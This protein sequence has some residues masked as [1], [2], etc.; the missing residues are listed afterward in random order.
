MP[1]VAGDIKIRLSGGSGNTDPNASLGG[2][3]SSTEVT[4][5]SLHN[6]FDVVSSGESSSGDTEYRCIYVHNGHATLTLQSAKV[7][8]QS[9]TSSGDTS[10]EIALAGEGLNATAETIANE[11]TAPAGET[12]SAP[13]TEGAGLTLGNIPAGQH[14]AVWVKRIVNAA[15]AAFNTDTAILR[16]KGD[17]AA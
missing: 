15:A 3:K 11:S 8:I 4:D 6:L 7:W 9:Q 13:S 1:I 10:M 16:V 14:Y 5:A 12:F 2:V 17:T